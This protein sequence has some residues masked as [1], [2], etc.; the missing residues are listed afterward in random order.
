MEIGRLG[1]CDR[2][3]ESS[4]EIQT[5]KCHKAVNMCQRALTVVTI[6]NP[7]QVLCIVKTAQ[8]PTGSN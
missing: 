5:I 6:H 3:E 1:V 2:R 7:I 8:I 4:K